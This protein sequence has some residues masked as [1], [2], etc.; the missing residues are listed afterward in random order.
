MLL[1]SPNVHSDSRLKNCNDLMLNIFINQM[2]FSLHEH[3][4]P[5]DLHLICFEDYFNSEILTFFFYLN[6]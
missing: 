3:G 1:I 6:K 2:L 5:N 4:T